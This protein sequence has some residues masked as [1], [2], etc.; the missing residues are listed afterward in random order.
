VKDAN[1]SYPKVYINDELQSYYTT[2][3]KINLI[4]GV[5]TIV[6]KATNELGKSTTVTKTI[7]LNSGAPTL[8]VGDIPDNT[9]SQKLSISWTVKDSN[10]P[11]PKV[12]INDALQSYYTTSLSVDLIE[13]ENTFTFKATNSNGKSTSISKKITFTPPAPVLSFGYMPVNTTSSNISVSWN[14]SDKNDSY[15]KVYLNDILQSYY[16]T[17]TSMSLNVGANQIN[18]V[19]TNKYGKQSSVTQTVYRN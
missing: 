16:Q 7:T 15:P 17:N 11:Y 19:A 6:F 3:A 9:T 4:D 10:D 1:D 8:T 14:V 5:N 18:L 2:T 13:G 12:Y